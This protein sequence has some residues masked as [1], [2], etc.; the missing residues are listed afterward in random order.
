MSDRL[1]SGGAPEREDGEWVELPHGWCWCSSDNC[2]ITAAKLYIP[3]H[4]AHECSGLMRSLSWQLI[5]T[6]NTLWFPTFQSNTR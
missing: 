1:D 4:H 5:P 3:K 2:Q 6:R